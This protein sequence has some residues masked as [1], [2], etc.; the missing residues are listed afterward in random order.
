MKVLITGGAGFIG[1]NL[2]KYLQ[3]NSNHDVEIMDNLSSGNK[4]E[5]QRATNEDIVFHK[6]DIT[7]RQALREIAKDKDVIV[8]LAAQVDVTESLENPIAD[9][10]NNLDGLLNILEISR[11]EDLK[12]VQASSVA[13]ADSEELPVNE[14]KPHSPKSPYGASKASAE[15][16]CKA[17]SSSYNIETVCLRFANVYGPYSKGKNDVISIFLRNIIQ[18]K[19]LQ[20]YGDGEQTR[21][22][23]HVRDV[24]KAIENMIE[25]E[26]NDI[27][28]N[29]GSGESISVNDLVDLIDRI[30]DH[31][32]KVNHKSQREGDIKHMETD[33]SRISS[34]LDFQ[35]SVDLKE[36]IKDTFEYWN[37]QL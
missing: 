17:Y 5:L 11:K 18:N 23:I 15:A 8:N 36:G 32:V 4:D 12:V 6:A 35:P 26:S 24:C 13:V 19:E 7:D 9:K 31:E 22:F 37:R 30:A 21:D 2:V 33:I 14:E 20:I 1:R 28:Y 29:L 3:E 25:T 16:Y 34:E 10:K 27:V